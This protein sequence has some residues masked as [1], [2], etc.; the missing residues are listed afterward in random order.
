MELSE[1]TTASSMERQTEASEDEGVS[2]SAS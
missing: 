2:R 1:R